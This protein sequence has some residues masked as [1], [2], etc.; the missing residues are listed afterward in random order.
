MSKSEVFGM[1]NS[2][3]FITTEKLSVKQTF[4]NRYQAEKG[5]K[6]KKTLRKQVRNRS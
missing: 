5:R 6:K 4:N 1:M 2:K 3:T